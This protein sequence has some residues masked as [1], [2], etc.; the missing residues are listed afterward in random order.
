MFK[1]INQLNQYALLIR[2][3]NEQRAVQLF[4]WL[5]TEFPTKQAAMFLNQ[6]QS[7]SEEVAG[8]KV[9]QLLSQCDSSGISKRHS[10]WRV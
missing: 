10:L 9:L 8:M 7:E 5:R 2:K 3:S 6:G 1:K 4:N